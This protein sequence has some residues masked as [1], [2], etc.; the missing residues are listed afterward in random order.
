MRD[1]EGVGEGPVQI[2]AVLVRHVELTGHVGLRGAELAGVPEQPAHGVGAAQLD[3]GPVRVARLRAVPGA[4]EHR[5]RAADERLE[6]LGEAL[7]DAGVAGRGGAGSRGA[8]VEGGGGRGHRSS[9]GVV[10]DLVKVS[11]LTSR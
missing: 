9:P 3:D 10:P 6:G 11:W 2:P 5:Q 1:G 4:Q 8:G 7:R